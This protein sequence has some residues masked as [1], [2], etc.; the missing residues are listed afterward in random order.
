MKKFLLTIFMVLTGLATQYTYGQTFAYDQVIDFQNPVLPSASTGGFQTYG[1]FTYKRC[2]QQ[3]GYYPSW[4]TGTT[5]PATD[6][7][8]QFQNGTNKAMFSLPVMTEGVNT[9]KYRYRHNGLNGNPRTVNVYRN[10]DTTGTALAT[11]VTPAYTVQYDPCCWPEAILTLNDASTTDFYTIVVTGGNLWIDNLVVSKNVSNPAS[12]TTS[13][14]TLALAAQSDENTPSASQSFT[15]TASNLSGDVVVTAPNYAEISTDDANWTNGSI[16]LASDGAGGLQAPAQIYVRS[17]ITAGFALA[18]GISL[19][20][21]A[22]TA[23]VPVSGLIPLEFYYKGDGGPL[24]SLSSWGLT[25]SGNGRTPTSFAIN[26]ANFHLID[27]NNVVDYPAIT[28]EWKIGNNTTTTTRL[29]LGNNSTGPLT[30]NF[31]PGGFIPQ[32]ANQQGG[33]RIRFQ[34]NHTIKVNDALF[35]VLEVNTNTPDGGSYQYFPNLVFTGNNSPSNGILYVGNLTVEAGN[36]ATKNIRAFNSVTVNEGAILNPSAGSNKILLE[37]GAAVNIQGTLRVRKSV[38]GSFISTSEPTSTGNTDAEAGGTLQYVDGSPNLTI[39]ANSTISYAR[40]GVQNIQDISGY[41]LSYATIQAVDDI[42][43]LTSN[44]T[45]NRIETDFNGKFQLGD[46]DLTTNSMGIGAPARDHSVIT[47][48]QGSLIVQM[49]DGQSKTFPVTTSSDPNE[50]TPIVITHTGA[51]NQYKVRVANGNACAGADNFINKNW[52]VTPVNAFSGADEAKLEMKWLTSNTAINTNLDMNAAAGVHC[53]AGNNADKRGFIKAVAIDGDFYTMDV[54]KVKE[55]SPFAV[56]S[57]PTVLS[58][59]APLAIKLEKFSAKAAGQGVKL[60]WATATDSDES[61]FEVEKSFDGNKFQTISTVQ[62]NVSN[63]SYSYFDNSE[64]SSN[65]YY[66]LKISNNEGKIVYSRIEVINGNSF[67]TISPNPAQNFVN[68]TTAKDFSIKSVKVVNS[69]GR[70]VMTTNTN[71]NA[72]N[73]SKLP[74][75]SYVL[76]IMS[77]DNRKLTRRIVKN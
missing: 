16:T 40:Q 59:A 55:F 13:P 43:S 52:N 30:L 15:V 74:K 9:I 44:I 49:A 11:L 19:V 51:N 45:A 70:E 36:V 3:A 53:D 6:K 32:T 38:S 10:Y 29:I 21:G 26:N 34:G 66:R 72:I 41:N 23:S 27:N 75:D 48:G 67:F 73:I 18:G 25:T 42:K 57:N 35:P 37:T 63:K 50:F 1:D 7:S 8:M 68:V 71:F 65:N 12:I 4:T 56:S 47:N 64:L 77:K 2:V 39:G 14:A 69:A 5:V 17:N 31:G 22:T 28:S 60:N 54:S 58:N 24:T 76:E 62:A 46:F 33:A 20:S 61:Y